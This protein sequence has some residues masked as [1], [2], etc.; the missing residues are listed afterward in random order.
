MEPSLSTLQS[1]TSQGPRSFT[2]FNDLPPEL[3]IKIWQQSLPGPRTVAVKS[4]YA[5]R[6]PSPK[7]LEDAV[8]QHGDDVETW[9][10]TTQI[11]ALLHVNAE[12]R[13][14]AL[15][16]YRLSLAVGISQPRVYV[17][18]SRDTLFFGNAELK[19]ECSSL[20]SATKDMD[21]VE[22]L[23]V[24]PEGAWRVFRWKKIDLNGLQKMIF[25]HDTEKLQLGPSPQLVEDDTHDDIEELVARIEE[26]QMAEIAMP[27]EPSTPLPEAAMKKR[28]EAAREEL[29]TLKTVLPAQWEKEP[30][31]VTAVFKKS[32]GD[33]WL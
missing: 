8:A 6:Q 20:W 29:D 13:H 2:R 23:A 18:F 30:V 27:S 22:R 32:C 14:E 25:V 3:R 9:T 10:S 28:M 11:P 4:P 15:K 16:H 31:V 1:S 5:Q 19:P 17:D 26:I 33:R 24:V 12:A 7:S 21:K